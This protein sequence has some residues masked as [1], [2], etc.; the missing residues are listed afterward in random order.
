M[1]PRRDF[2]SVI[3]DPTMT[4]VAW[5][6]MLREPL[7]ELLNYWDN[8]TTV[9]SRYVL[10][11]LYCRGLYEGV[12]KNRWPCFQLSLIDGH[13]EFYTC[14]RSGLEKVWAQLRFS[15]YTSQDGLSL[16]ID[17]AMGDE[18]KFS[19]DETHRILDS[20]KYR[21]SVSLLIDEAIRVVGIFPSKRAR[22]IYQ[23]IFWLDSA[24]ET[25]T[26]EQAL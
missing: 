6:S 19:P 10:K 11:D 1:Y 7:Q 15:L 9:H 14:V 21:F 13:P 16:L 24:I 22:D 17:E 18:I 26:E 4:D 8:P 3:E 2:R 23:R 5:R 25:G 12:V 20:M